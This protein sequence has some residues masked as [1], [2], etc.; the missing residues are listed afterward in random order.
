M[1]DKAGRGGEGEAA[2]GEQGRQPL[3]SWK[4]A[5]MLGALPLGDQNRGSR[6]RGGWAGWATGALGVIRSMCSVNSG[7]QRKGLK[8]GCDV[9]RVSGALLAE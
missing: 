9:T 8:W 1:R 2:V 4:S 5:D 3:A 7:E 6:A